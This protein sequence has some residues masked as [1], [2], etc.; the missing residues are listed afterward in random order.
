MSRSYRASSGK[1]VRLGQVLG[2]GG[3]GTVYSV[4]GD[5]QLAAKYYLPG[6]AKD[7][8]DKIVAMVQAGW[9]KSANDV[10]FPIDILSD[11]TGTFSG[12][13]MRRVGGDK[14]VH[15]LYS[16]TGRKTSFPNATYPF[17]VRVASN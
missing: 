13:T 14:P 10:A 8:R 3:E 4:D 9:H 1:I 15:E 11:Q 16:P 12:F 2:Q 7:R 6:L 5:K 17:L